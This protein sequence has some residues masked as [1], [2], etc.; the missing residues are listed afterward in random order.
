MAIN[1]DELRATSQSRR[2]D[3]SEVKGWECSHCN[4][5]FK[6]ETLFLRHTCTK[7]LRSQELKTPD[8]LAAYAYYA[9]WM[10]MNKYKAPSIETFASSRYFQAFMKFNIFCQRISLQTPHLYMKLMV[11]KDLSPTMWVRDQCHGIYLEWQDKTSDPFEQ[12]KITVN[13]I[14]KAAEIGDVEPKYV[15]T[16]LSTAE[17]LELIRRGLLSPWLLLCSTAFKEMLTKMDEDERGALLAIVN[18]TYW[19]AKMSAKPSVVE[20]AKQIAVELGI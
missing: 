4:K 9:E 15:F 12:I 13:T 1:I 2:A 14:S 17:I 3:I 20:A 18:V 6:N 16:L 11:E 8:G 5:V 19:S 7:M 10:K